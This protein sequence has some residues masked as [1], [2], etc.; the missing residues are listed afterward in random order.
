[1]VHCCVGVLFCCCCNLLIVGWGIRVLLFLPV[2]G[3]AIALLCFA[4]ETE[5]EGHL[6]EVQQLR[7][8]GTQ[9]GTG[10]PIAKQAFAGTSKTR[11]KREV[12]ILVSFVSWRRHAGTDKE[13]LHPRA[14]DPE[15]KEARRLPLRQERGQRFEQKQKAFCLL[16]RIWSGGA[17]RIEV[18]VGKVSEC[19]KESDLQNQTANLKA[20]LSQ[21]GQGRCCALLQVHCGQ[22]RMMFFG[23]GSS[24]GALKA[25]ALP[26]R[27]MIRL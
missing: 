16:Q 23:A 17:T 8:D 11:S 6:C 21:V 24:F 12:L 25:N 4:E 18:P 9:R 7:S 15:H 5:A 20:N 10:S 14:S 22:N 27:M 26:N 2:F 13:G 3:A 1:M 19:Q